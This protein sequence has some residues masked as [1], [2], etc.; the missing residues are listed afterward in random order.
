MKEKVSKSW[1]IIASKDH[2]QKGMD[3]GIAQACH[4]KRT[5]ISKPK[6]GDGVIYY[7]SKKKFE[8]KPL[9]DNIYQKFTSIG[10]FEDEEISKELVFH[11][12]KVIY[13]KNTKEVEIRPYLEKLEF[14]KDPKKW[15]MSVRNGM[16]EISKK[17]FEFIKGLML[18]Y[19][20]LCLL[21][22]FSSIL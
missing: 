11:R 8:E 1:L 22:S 20:S 4:G 15:G 12:R 6:K 5:S 7:S 10:F 18:N 19:F 3:L 9:K 21:F 2:V 13:E 14:I 16:R 17:D